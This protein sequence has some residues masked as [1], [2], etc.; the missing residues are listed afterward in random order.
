MRLENREIY[1]C[2]WAGRVY[3]LL[4]SRGSNLHTFPASQTCIPE[5]SREKVK[6][7]FAF[8]PILDKQKVVTDENV[9]IRNKYIREWQFGMWM[10]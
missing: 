9:R 7:N 6:V 5:I 1:G 3:Q 2:E 8:L 10:V 4:M